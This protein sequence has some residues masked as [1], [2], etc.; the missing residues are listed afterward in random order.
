M[1]DKILDS[2]T[3]QQYLDGTLDP[4]KMHELEKQ[5]LEDEFLADALEGYT[6]VIEPA[7]KLTILQQRLADR[8]LEQEVNKKAFSITAQRLSLAAASGLMFVLAAILFWMNGYHAAEVSKKVEV[9]LSAQPTVQSNTAKISTQTIEIANSVA[10]PVFAL[11]KQSLSRSEPV[12]GWNEYTKYIH[13]NIPKPASLKDGA[14]DLFIVFKISQS[15][16]P[17]DLKVA[18]GIAD[19]YSKEVIRVIKNGPLWK[20]IDDKEVIIQV[21]FK[22]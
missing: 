12:A 8:I 3:I 4:R 1:K 22:K 21:N 2:L 17:V 15:G 5:A 7:E 13:N 10:S 11:A 19:Q 9:N 18:D 16:T 20:P 6:Y 14:K